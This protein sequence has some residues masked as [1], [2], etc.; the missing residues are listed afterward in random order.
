MS[1][2]QTVVLT[3]AT[4]LH[5]T[6]D[7]ALFYFCTAPHCVIY[8]VRG[9]GQVPAGLIAGAWLALPRIHTFMIIWNVHKNVAAARPGQ[10]RTGFSN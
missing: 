8:M 4:G 6:C 1:L 5:F 3:V 2:Q 9:D 10:K 7:L